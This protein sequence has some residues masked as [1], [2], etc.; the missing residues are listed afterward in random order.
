ME[1]ISPTIT[2]AG[3]EAIARYCEQARDAIE[4]APDI[5]SAHKLKDAFCSRLADECRSILVVKATRQYVEKL[6]A[7]RWPERSNG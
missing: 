1:R 5:G 4:S 3:E 7:E 6:I 2:S